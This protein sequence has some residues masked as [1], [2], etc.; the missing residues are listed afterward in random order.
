MERAK[1]VLGNAYSLGRPLFIQLRCTVL[2]D[3][4]PAG[5]DDDEYC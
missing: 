5:G 2:C 1:H 4:M 3:T